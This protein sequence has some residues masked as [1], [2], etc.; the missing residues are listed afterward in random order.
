MEYVNCGFCNN[1]NIEVLFSKKDKFGISDYDFKIV[2]CKNCGLIFVNPRPKETEITKFY[3]EEYSWKELVTPSSK[4]PRLIKKLEKFYRYQLLS[5]EVNKALRY[6]GL[7]KGRVLDIGCGTGDRLDIFR[8]L[9]FDTFGVEFSSSARYAKEYLRLNVF[10]GD[11]FRANYPDDFFNIVTLYNVLE[12]VHRPV[13]LLWEIKR[14]LKNRGFLVI[15]VPNTDSLQFKIF[16]QRW[17]AFDVPRDIY[18]FSSGLLE[19]IL[20]LVGFEVVGI[21]HFFHW[22]HPPT[23]TLTLLPGLDP[24]LNWKKESSGVLS[25]ASRISWTLLTF[26][27]IPFFTFFESIIKKSA[28][29]TAYAHKK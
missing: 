8:N 4:I 25:I 24:Q 18:Y 29:I 16:K 13:E 23:L 6:T 20:R 21:N 15:G 19:K 5:Y 7:K 9:G 22:F 11:L 26:M 27:V 28:L 3:P 14:I 10:E 17:A 12:H 1:D 2:R